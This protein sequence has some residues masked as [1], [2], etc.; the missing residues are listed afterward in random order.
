MGRLVG[1]RLG[2]LFFSMRVVLRISVYS[3]FF[4]HEIY[5]AWCGT[6]CRPLLDCQAVAIGDGTGR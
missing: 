6:R 5:W 1:L 4:F 3:F 2:V